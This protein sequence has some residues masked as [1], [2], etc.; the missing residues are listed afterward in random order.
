MLVCPCN[1][2]KSLAAS[3]HFI[4]TPVPALPALFSSLSNRQQN[5]ENPQ[6]ITGK[7]QYWAG[8]MCSCEVLSYL[9]YIWKSE[10]SRLKSFIYFLHVPRASFLLFQPELGDLDTWQENTNAWEEE[11]D[12]AWQAE[13]VLR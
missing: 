10:A 2:Q 1:F 8:E 7:S 5:Q 11:E 3:V 9:K 6:K 12:A 4:C 13:E